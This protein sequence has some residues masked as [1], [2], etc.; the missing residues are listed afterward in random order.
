MS[1]RQF[2]KDQQMSSVILLKNK[3]GKPDKYR[4]RQVDWDNFIEEFD[5]INCNKMC[6]LSKPK[7]RTENLFGNQRASNVFCRW[8]SK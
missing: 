8:C 7:K 2:I 5:G 4:V 1:L 3:G 6:N